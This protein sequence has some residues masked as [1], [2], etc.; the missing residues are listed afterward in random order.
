[1]TE[2]EMDFEVLDTQDLLGHLY[3]PGVGSATF[4]LA[5]VARLL[6]AESPPPPD[7]VLRRV[8]PARGELAGAAK[9]RF[10]WDNRKKMEPLRRKGAVES[11]ARVDRAISA[12]FDT[13]AAYKDFDPSSR[14]YKLAVELIEDV[15]PDGVWPITSVRYELEHIK[16]NELLERLRGP[17]AAHVDELN[18][19]LFV[20]RAERLNDEYGGNLSSLNNQAVDYDDVEAAEHAAIEA[21][22]EVVLVIWAA[23]IDDRATRARLLAPVEEQNKRIAEYYKERSLIPEVDPETGEVIEPEKPSDDD[24][25]GDSDAKK[26]TAAKKDQDAAVEP[27]VEP[28][29]SDA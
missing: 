2:M 22:F 14:Y 7:W 12:I 11:D 24:E 16:V 6:A 5:G 3:K 8:A 20:D 10:D 27:A 26:E 28:E 23:Y 1:M 25:T 21:Y 13:A 4:A 15:F 18:L 17:L 19:G 29:A 9:I